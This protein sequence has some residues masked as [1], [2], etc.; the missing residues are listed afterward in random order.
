M[1]VCSEILMNL[2][3]ARNPVL[4]ERV[5][6]GDISVHALLTLPFTELASEQMKS[7]R[8]AAKRWEMAERRSDLQPHVTITDAFRCGKCRQRKCSYY[9]MQTRSADEPM[10]TFVG[11]HT[12]IHGKHSCMAHGCS[13]TH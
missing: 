7:E 11:T 4:R 9:Q 6:N 1:S 8:D 13:A 2:K 12:H 5:L 3:D 10:T